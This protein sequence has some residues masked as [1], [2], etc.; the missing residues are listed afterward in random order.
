[1][2]RLLPLLLA[3]CLSILL[4]ARGS[5]DDPVVAVDG[6]SVYVVQPG[7]T[8]LGICRRRGLD[9]AEVAASNGI[10]DWNRIY[11]GQ[12]LLLPPSAAP[13][14]PP[15]SLPTP[16][17][18]EA[19]Y[20][21]QP[22]DTLLRVARR[23]GVAVETLARLNGIASIDRIVVGQVLR[24]PQVV[25]DPPDPA[26]Q[27]QGGDIGTLLEHAA[28]A[29][30]LDPA[31]VKALAW[32]QTGWRTGATA[33][34]LGVLGVTPPTYAWVE[35]YLLGRQLVRG[36]PADD[37]EAG[38]AY[39]SFLQRAVDGDE[40]MALAAYHQGLRSVRNRGITDATAR[41]VE[42]VLRER[43]RFA[44]APEGMSRPATSP[45]PPPAEPTP[46][47]ARI[48]EL[49]LQVE[50]ARVGVA[51][52]H[53]DTDARVEWHANE[54]F[55]SASVLKLAILIELERQIAYGDLDRDDRLDRLAEAMIVRSDNDAAN[56]LMD[57]MGIDNINQTLQELGLEHT[58][59]RNHFGTQPNGDGYNQT[60]PAEMAQILRRMA[61]GKLISKAASD[62]M[63]DLLGRVRDSS[64]LP[65][66]LPDDA[67]V[68]HKSGWYDSVVN[69]VGIVRA[70]GGTYVLAVFTAD[71]AD[72]DTADRLI[73]QISRSV[74]NAWGR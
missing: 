66:L 46:L 54:V 50:G 28:S 31:L 60:T 64:R 1:M 4:I 20:V 67:R 61:R 43:P 74:Y 18:A 10:S 35:S 38:V 14:P 29:H 68:A 17:P 32:A 49:V 47:E 26:P 24:V 52:Y 33:D 56:Q 40:R 44:A 69:D 59:L 8:L 25:P 63:L 12:R 5:T 53:L 21:V 55:P 13:L 72:S 45:T 42:S 2:R 34:G 37:I 27:H 36:D 39:L 48:G 51:G 71:I 11:V 3:G 23:H 6:Q 15:T 41:F 7:D 9:P 19:T 22:G 57:M 65:R 73:A 62:R 70:P 30:G 58:V 16:V